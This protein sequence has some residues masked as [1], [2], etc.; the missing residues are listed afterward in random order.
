MSRLRKLSARAVTT[1]AAVGAAIVL[2]AG[3]AMAA[4]VT[5]KVGDP[6]TNPPTGVT[7]LCT[8]PGI[9]PQPVVVTAQLDAPDSIPSG[10]TATP[11]NVGG[12]ATITGAV[13]SL[14]TAVGYDGIRGTASVPVTLTNGT[15]SQP[16]ATGLEVP[17]KIYPADG[18]PITVVIS[19]VAT[20][21]IPTATAGSPGT[22]TLSLG[23]QLTAQ[24]QFHRGSTNTWTP[25][26]MTCNLK[27]TTP[28]QNTA[29]TPS[30]TIT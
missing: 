7:Y 26:N 6:T 24:L 18:K 30:I 16:A 10:G 8:F 20:S 2:T 25:Y 4:T 28:P 5:Y 14:L 19:Q 29:F 11:S 15:L 21:S 22:A 13:H 27:A 17:E 23:Q 12:T 9:Q 1:G 3:T